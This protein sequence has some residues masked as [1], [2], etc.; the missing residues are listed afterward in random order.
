ME[1]EVIRVIYRERGDELLKLRAMTVA[2]LAGVLFAVSCGGS[3]GPET[4][5]RDYYEA[6]SLGNAALLPNLFVPEVGSTMQDVTLPSITVENL[7]IET[8]LQTEDRAQLIAEY[9]VD[10]PEDAHVRVTVLLEKQGTRW[11][12]SELILPPPEG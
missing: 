6:L 12:I 5:V 4:T 9:D 1:T 8:V 7:E 3:T 11:L 2:M 10:F